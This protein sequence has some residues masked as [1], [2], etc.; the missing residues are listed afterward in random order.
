MSGDIKKFK[1]CHILCKKLM[2]LPYR[3]IKLSTVNGYC[4]GTPLRAFLIIGCFKFKTISSQVSLEN[5]TKKCFTF[6]S[7]VPF[8]VGT[9]Y[10]LLNRQLLEGST[11]V[12]L[13]VKACFY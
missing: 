11:T 7:M 12:Y 1:I 9:I 8:W 2:F 4:K 13:C 6:T 3:H 5:V 10:N